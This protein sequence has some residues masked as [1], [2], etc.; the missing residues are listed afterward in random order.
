[1]KT[2]Y[3]VHPISNIAIEE[4]LINIYQ[5]SCLACVFEERIEKGEKIKERVYHLKLSGTE[6]FII[7][8]SEGR[9]LRNGIEVLEQ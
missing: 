5:I 4:L 8:E 7:S 1:M 2:F 3:S 9:I 6:S